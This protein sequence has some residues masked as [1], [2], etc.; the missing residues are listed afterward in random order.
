MKP[1]PG[2][3]LGPYEILAPLGTGGMGEVWRAIDGRLGREVAIKVLP[4]DV[5]QDEEWRQRFEREAR[6]AARLSHPHVC[7]IYDVGR[8]GPRDYLVLDLLEGETLATR[9]TRGPLPFG[10]VL[11]LGAQ[12]AQA[13]AAA[14][15]IGI[16]HR[17]LKP[18]NVILT[19][20]GVKLLDFGL[21]KEIARP[22]SAG[23]DPLG[24]TAGMGLTRAGA[25][26]GTAPYMSPEQATGKPVD[27]RTDIFALGA[28][29]YEM[30][31]GRRAFPGAS[32]A[33]ALGAVL[34]REP[35]P[36]SSVRPEVPRWFDQLVATC[37][38]K[39]P[40]ERWDS[41]HDLAI[42]LGAP[43]TETEPA[44]RGRD[45]RGPRRA[46]LGAMLLLGLLLGAG[47]VSLLRR[48]AAPGR[49][50]RPVR[51]VQP[52]PPGTRIFHNR[53]VTSIAVSPD[54]T[55]VAFITYRSGVPAVWLRPEGRQVW[56]RD[57]S[58]AEPRAVPSTEGATSVFWSPDGTALGFVVPGAM[59]R[60]ALEGG[61][62][63]TICPLEKQVG[64][65]A[66]W[67]PDGRIV[68][69][70]VLGEALLEVAS[71]GGEPRI[72]L[73][74]DRGRGEF[75]FNWP[76]HLPGGRLLFLSRKAD[77][78]AW[79]MLVMPGQAPR[80]VM[81]V[82]SRVQ[83][84]EPDVL[85]YV[86]GGTLVAQRFDVE[87]GAVRGEP[88]AL[89]SH[90]RSFESNGS[91]EFAAS[92]GG[93]VVWQPTEDVQSLRWLDRSG[94]DLGALGESGV[95]ND[96]SIS[97]VGGAVLA[98]RARTDSGILDVWSFDLSTGGAAP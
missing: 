57:L 40:S 77:L 31:T 27:G 56:I 58:Q 53:E 44:L 36:P 30:A 51:L 39:E 85:I 65:A 81:P 68:F 66:S 74:P 63:V 34:T 42:R 15:A 78:S 93:T 10:E 28:V 25:V 80:P 9:L 12:I 73:R 16:V 84:T 49:P 90:V 96:V 69:S 33:E 35:P 75:A 83:F 43:P 50:E 67:G 18:G 5:S 61:P 45:G 37:L 98:S 95:W 94:K 71:A 2:A 92:P 97:P 82:K 6:S 24:S 1:G 8:D 55:R 22:P 89:A 14:H 72:L 86:R 26:L 29:M 41:V 47:L 4:A 7:A 54:G 76:L 62:A 91:A 23:L 38:A 52:P 48:P 13:L 19:A 70:S 79:L 88:W 3:R 46:W 64:Y 11:R 87:S 60:V 17:D 21:A 20:S 59:K 32:H